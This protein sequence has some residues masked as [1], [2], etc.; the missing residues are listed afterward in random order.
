MATPLDVGIDHGLPIRLVTE[1]NVGRGVSDKAANRKTIDI[2]VLLKSMITTLS[3]MGM[4][5]GSDNKDRSKKEKALQIYRTSTMLL[6]VAV[7]GW[8]FSNINKNQLAAIPPIIWTM[9]ATAHFGIFYAVSFNSSCFPRFLE[10]WQAYR[11]KYY[12][13]PGSMKFKS[14]ACASVIVIL[15]CLY[16]AFKIYIFVDN[17]NRNDIDI[18]S[19]TLFSV[20][21]LTGLYYVFSWLASSGFMLLIAKLLADEYHLIY[22]QMQQIC[23]EGSHLLN[24]RIGDIRRRHWELSKVVSK[25]DDIFCVHMG[26]SVATLLALTCIGLYLIIWDTSIQGNRTLEIIRIANVLMGFTKLT[27]DCVAGVII[28]DAVSVMGSYSTRLLFAQSSCVL[29]VRYNV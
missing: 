27:S 4:M 11:D 14:T 3:V 28:H 2:R 25:A 12:V 10:M 8:N 26:L 9:Q 24:Q 1:R 13:L 19:V 6:S 15:W 18:Y 20:K 29:P 23:D 21:I 5:F 7:C 22:R 16:V 17:F